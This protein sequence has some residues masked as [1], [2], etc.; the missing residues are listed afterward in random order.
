MDYQGSVKLN[1]DANF[2][3]AQR[4][5]TRERSY[6]DA[7]PANCSQVKGDA[8]ANLE[9]CWQSEQAKLPKTNGMIQN[10]M[11]IEL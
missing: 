6:L 9:S 1:R 8:K 3:A 4:I 5:V 10:K 2:F 7:C 11:Y